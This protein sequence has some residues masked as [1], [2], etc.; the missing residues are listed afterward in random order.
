MILVCRCFAIESLCSHF[1]CGWRRTSARRP[2]RNVSKAKRASCQLSLSLGC[3]C[4]GSAAA[5]LLKP[6]AWVSS[7]RSNV[8]LK[9][10]LSRI[11]VHMF[12]SRVAVDFNVAKV[13]HDEKDRISSRTPLA[14]I[15]RARAKQFV[16]TITLNTVK[17]ACCPNKRQ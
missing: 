16:W 3:Y 12:R 10:C 6:N 11:P 14:L 1:G 13:L 8:R 5:L 2:R 4:G 17:I 15:C 9:A 7:Y